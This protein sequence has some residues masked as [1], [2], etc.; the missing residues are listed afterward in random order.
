MIQDYRKRGG[1]TKIHGYPTAQ[2]INRLKVELCVIAV[3]EP[4]SL[5]GGRHGHLGMILEENEYLA[6]SNHIPFINPTNPGLFPTT[7]MTE[8]TL[9]RA[10]AEHDERVREFTV[11]YAM[12]I[13]LKNKILEAVDEDYLFCL[14][15]DLIGYHRVTP[16]DMLNELRRFAA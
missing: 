9:N 16:R 11:Y 13:V 12:N 3:D 6:Y 8:E 7:P 2:D 14:K 4:T 5:G 15:E 10:W 1:V